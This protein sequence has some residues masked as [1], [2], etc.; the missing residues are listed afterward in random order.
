MIKV[1]FDPET[2]DVVW[3]CPVCKDNGYIRNW[4][5]TVWDL[6]GPGPDKK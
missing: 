1:D 4:K 6:T 3:W 5:G 2:E